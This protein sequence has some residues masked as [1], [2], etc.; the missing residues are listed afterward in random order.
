MSVKRYICNVCGDG[1][2]PCLLTST[3][4]DF[5]PVYCPYDNAVT[6]S[7]GGESPAKWG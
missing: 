3:G 6:E 4:E 7:S 5:K 2:D 1:E